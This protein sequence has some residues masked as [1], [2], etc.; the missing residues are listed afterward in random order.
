MLKYTI[1]LFDLL[2]SDLLMR[3][4]NN[5]MAQLRALNIGIDMMIGLDIERNAGIRVSDRQRSSCLTA[6]ERRIYLREERKQCAA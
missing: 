4:H 1:P 5:V 3:K 6:A 2:Q